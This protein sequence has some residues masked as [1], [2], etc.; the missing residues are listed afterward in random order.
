MVCCDTSFLAALI[1][2]DPQAE[3]LLDEYLALEAELSTTPITACELFK[4]AYKSK[5]DEN[6]AKVRKMLAYLKILDLSVDA[7]DRYGRLL[8]ELQMKG[9]PT[10]DLDA[11]IASIALA[12]GEPLITSDTNHFQNVPG[13][14][15]RSW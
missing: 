1:R 13:L 15:L 3:K 6:V 4:G 14:V 7:C 12:F 5:K 9:S 8:N 11:M 10:S 2:R